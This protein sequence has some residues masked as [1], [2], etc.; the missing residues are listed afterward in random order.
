M[1]GLLTVVMILTCL[2]PL[3]APEPLVGRA[4]VIDGDTI[5]VTGQRVRLHGIDAP[6][7]A[8][9]CQDS[10]GGSYACSRIAAQ[11]LDELLAASRPARCMEKDRDRYSQGTYAT[12]QEEA[13]AAR[14]GG[15]GRE[16][17]RPGN[18]ANPSA[19]GAPDDDHRN[20]QLTAHKR[21]PA[22]YWYR[23]NCIG[24]GAS[25][26]KSGVGALRADDDAAAGDVIVKF[27][28]DIPGFS[29]SERSCS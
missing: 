24:P 11:K 28:I 23:L 6:E 22:P 12:A 17:S 26:G 10:R 18:G 8:Q 16:S 27:C 1:Q 7:P 19:A 3:Q 29:S 4:S 5:E 21:K 13:R 25:F 14:G 2:T 9:Q 20:S 15:Y